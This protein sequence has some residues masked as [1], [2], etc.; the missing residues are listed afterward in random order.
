MFQ[1][2]IDSKRT[3]ARSGVRRQASDSLVSDTIIHGCVCHGRRTFHREHA[4]EA[5]LVLVDLQALRL[6]KL[7]AQLASVPAADK[8]CFTQRI[9]K[10]ARMMCRHDFLPRG[11]EFFWQHSV[12]RTATWQPA[13]RY[14]ILQDRPA[15]QH[16]VV[17]RHPACPAGPGVASCASPAR[18]RAGRRSTRSVACPRA[19]TWK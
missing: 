8:T 7:S 5:V 16:G 15:P 12:R 1:R 17:P 10:K 19:A 11:L 13:R 2:N 14:L 9:S 3:T 4:K 6:R 18:A